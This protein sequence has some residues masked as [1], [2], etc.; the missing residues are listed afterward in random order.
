MFYQ[1]KKVLC[2]WDKIHGTC[3]RC[4]SFPHSIFKALI[5]D[6]ENTI[7]NNWIKT[8]RLK[9]IK[10]KI[11]YSKHKTLSPGV[12]GVPEPVVGLLCLPCPTRHFCRMEAQSWHGAATS[13]V[14][15]TR[16]VS[17]TRCLA[18]VAPH[19][20]VTRVPTR[21]TL[22][23]GGTARAAAALMETALATELPLAGGD[24]RSH[25]LKL[26]Q[27][28]PAW[29]KLSFFNIFSPSSI[30]FFFWRERE[31]DTAYYD[32]ASKNKYI[33]IL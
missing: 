19:G 6:M 21:V 32:C 1:F 24:K 26:D 20:E 28:N 25:L 33:L 30:M 27:R 16:L 9:K 12:K 11:N 18:E 8:S 31:R 22:S 14:S 5:F 4:H 29:I 2:S 17:V 13:A 3:I 7:T 23:L 15:V 10:I